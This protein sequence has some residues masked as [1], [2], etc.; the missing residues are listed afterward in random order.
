MGALLL[1]HGAFGALHLACYLPECAGG[2]KEHAAEHQPAAGAAGNAHEHPAGYA[3]S[4]EYFAVVAFG[5]L[6][7]LLRWLPKGTP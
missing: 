3:T 4:P 2:A 1:C 6:G 5:L 7:L